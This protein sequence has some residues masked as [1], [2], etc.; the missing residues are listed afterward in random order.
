MALY[1]LDYRVINPGHPHELWAVLIEADSMVAAK[2]E[3]E[4]QIMLKHR[5]G[6]VEILGDP[7]LV[8]L[9]NHFLV[10]SK[11]LP[12]LRGSL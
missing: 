2:D 10:G 6:K 9:P 5:P 11:V 3:G 1:R 12:Q 7:K 8:E 4:G